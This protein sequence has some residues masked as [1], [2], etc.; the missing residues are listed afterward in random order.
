[1]C[2]ASPPSPP[3]TLAPRPQCPP[4]PAPARAR[5]IAHQGNAPAIPIDAPLQIS[6][7]R[8]VS[9]S[10]AASASTF[11]VDHPRLHT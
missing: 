3:P 2:R 11:S 6:M 10:Y 8:R 4:P 9:P 5:F 7:P 1:M